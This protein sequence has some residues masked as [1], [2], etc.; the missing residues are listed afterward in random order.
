MRRRD[1]IRRIGAVGA[2]ATGAAG[3]ASAE[4]EVYVDWEFPDGTTERIEL[5][6]FDRRSDT[7]SVET[8]DL[9]ETE[10]TC[11]AWSDNPGCRDCDYDLQT[12]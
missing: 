5:A 1:V 3:V 6:E 4:T 8:L 12:S 7:P 10:P 9:T 11:C 2:V